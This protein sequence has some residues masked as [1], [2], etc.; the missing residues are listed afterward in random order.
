LPGTN[1]LVYYEHFVI[2]GRESFITFVPGQVNKKKFETNLPIRQHADP[3]LC[4]DFSSKKIQSS[5]VIEKI[6]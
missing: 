4:R 1:T 6:Q 3:L 2:Y 5:S